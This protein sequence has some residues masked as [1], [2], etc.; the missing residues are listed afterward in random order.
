MKYRPEIDGLRAIAVSSVILFHAGF[1]I[2]SG[3]FVGVDVFFV[4]SGYL[5]TSVIL[6]DKE[7]GTF[8]IA[9]F[10]E[11]RARRILP[12]L[13]L[14][15]ASCIPFA[16]YSLA[17]NDMK[18]FSQSLIAVSLF[19]SNILFWRVSGYFETVA[20]LKPLLH[21]WSLA[22][23]EQFYLLFP[24]FL[25]LVWRLGKRVTVWLMIL[26]ALVSLAVAHWGAHNFPTPTYFLL[27]T[28]G[29]ELLIGALTA[30]FL[31]SEKRPEFSPLIGEVGSLAGLC[32]ITYSV[33]AF[34]KTTPFPSL[35]ALAPTI[36]ASLI[37]IFAN[38]KTLVGKLLEKKLLVGL[39]LISYSAYLWHQPL[40]AFARYNSRSELSELVLLILLLSTIALSCLTWKFV[41]QPFRKSG[42]F[43]RGAIL[44][45]ALFGSLIF[46][47]IGLVGSY[48]NGFEKLYT[49]TRLTEDQRRLYSLVSRNIDGDMDAD[50]IDNGD[51]NFWS[52][53]VEAL[54]E[55]RF[56]ACQKKYGKAI[57][58]LGD[59]HAMNIYNAIAKA[60]IGNFVVGVS[61][62]NCRPYDSPDYC[63]YDL[64]DK[65]V[66]RKKASIRRV[67]YHQSGSIL[68]KT[69]NGRAVAQNHFD[70]N[71]KVLVNYAGIEQIRS[72][73]DKTSD[74]VDTV[75]LGPFVEA[76]VNLKDVRRLTAGF[77]INKNSIIHSR[78][79]EDELKT[80]AAAAKWRFEY[81]SLFDILNIDG[82][83]LRIDDCITYRDG[84][85]LNR[86]GEELVGA[87][88][89][90]SSKVNAM[91]H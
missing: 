40:F 20:E 17:P 77:F 44:K 45:F 25:L 53:T 58:I 1:E 69:K 46:I 80:Q 70:S 34:S 9:S 35:Y 57:I 67:V 22:V 72:Y 23:E 36:G 7:A 39:G 71:K 74:T 8:S 63:R 79:I 26:G 64:F 88:L 68:M 59:S 76:R 37:I 27:P 33:I 48:T 78:F 65:F 54:S 62:G 3:G 11:R 60:K 49:Q 66:A 47:A 42:T 82:G 50:M 84:D 12:A 16:W 51:C 21:T 24:I 86:C 38:E 13:F 6:T 4:I 75:W 85:H 61:H 29:W 14:V 56:D 31:F 10:Y 87:K 41:E 73:L 83:F 55:P 91:F 15:M 43:T 90:S 52:R 30:Y 89:K 81:I 28:R 5:I 18:E 2:F 19:I 32:L